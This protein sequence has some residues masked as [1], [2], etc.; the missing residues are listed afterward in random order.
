MYNVENYVA[1]TLDSALNQT[2][3]NLEIIVVDDGSTDRSGEIVNEYA[4]RDSR[5]KVLTQPNAGLGA[6][7]NAGIAE[8]KGRYLTFL[9]SDDII[10]PSAYEDMVKTL[11]VTGS[12]F[13]VGAV[14]RVTHGKFSAPQWCRVTHDKDRLGITIDD[15]SLAMQ[16]IIACNR[17]FRTEF[18]RERIGNFPEGVA[19]EDHAPM[20]AAYVRATKFD[21][22]RRV[23]YYWRIRE[24]QKSIGQQKHSIQNLKDRKHAKEQ[25][26]RVISA[27]A[28]SGV[29]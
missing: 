1:E 14:R 11:N 19:Y 15:F 24:D 26:L 9:D 17:M 4:S 7:R 29:R 23:T 12:D 6:A 10:P 2:L 5:I 18:W 8:A 27:E 22:L 28:S 25:A 21:M 16:D 3:Q 13:A 20:V